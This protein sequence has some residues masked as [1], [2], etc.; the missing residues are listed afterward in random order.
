LKE[1][2]D[3]FDMLTNARAYQMKTGEVQRSTDVTQ[4]DA[5]KTENASTQAPG[6]DAATL[7]RT[8][9]SA[10]P[11]PRSSVTGTGASLA[12]GK[13]GAGK[14][15]WVSALRIQGVG[16]KTSYTAKE[17]LQI[18][19]DA[20]SKPFTAFLEC[21]ANAGS[22][23]I[24]GRPATQ[25][26]K[27]A[28]RS[29]TEHF[30]TAA[31]IVPAAGS[32]QTVGKMLN[33]IN[34]AANGK[35][36]TREE[37]IE[38]LADGAAMVDVVIPGA[39]TRPANSG[40]GPIASGSD[41]GNGGAA[42]APSSAE[43]A[44]VSQ[45]KELAKFGPLNLAPAL[46]RAE[47][48]RRID[49]FAA[50]VTFYRRDKQATSDFPAVIHATGYQERLGVLSVG[51]G[52]D[53]TSY[54]AGMGADLNRSAPISVSADLAKA[55]VIKLGSGRNGVAAINVNF[56]DL[57]P[58]STTIVTGGPMRGSTML[59][60]ADEGGLY[61]YHAQVPK[62]SSAKA[63]DAAASSIA[64]AAERFGPSGAPVSTSKA[65][66][67]GFD[68]LLRA[69]TG[70]PF[71]AVVY[72]YDNASGNQPHPKYGPPV[73]AGLNSQGKL[74]SMLNFN[75]LAPDRNAG[76][77]GNAK[78]VITKAMDGRVTVRVVASRGKLEDMR[79]SPRSFSYREIENAQGS[80]TTRGNGS[81]GG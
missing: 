34:N 41:R 44:S 58:G 33:R 63:S 30:D 52:K 61:A 37:L 5:G 73:D 76:E 3:Y 32:M 17:V 16:I 8:T 25:Q 18:A 77:V 7:Q 29:I 81:F 67:S 38:D 35:M 24:D 27:D 72:S 79:N 54:D 20:F 26:Q 42:N 6:K 13:R 14:D 31:G 50:P 74:W 66:R 1:S 46:N 11:P 75:Y 47:D 80:F 10:A 22:L 78:A 39:R 15:N 51:T 53:L 65:P 64:T 21:T 56:A 2:F 36:P 49:A 40:A 4:G 45:T 43:Q 60:T 19:G 57:E 71:S 48:R 23:L 55:S 68:G 62:R 28:I 9:R 12:A 59:F 69:A 70:S